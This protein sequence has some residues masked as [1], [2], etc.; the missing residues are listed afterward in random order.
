VNITNS[1]TIVAD[2]KTANLDTKLS[3]Q[4]ERAYV[5]DGSTAIYMHPELLV[6]L[7]SAYVDNLNETDFKMGDFN[8]KLKTWQGVPIITTRNMYNGT[9]AKITL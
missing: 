2:M 5:G 7:E 8:N 9:E 4:L 6:Y 1:A 3:L